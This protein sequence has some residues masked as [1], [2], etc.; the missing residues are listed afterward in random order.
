MA[1]FD[2]LEISSPASTGTYQ[3]SHSLGVVPKVAICFGGGNTALNGSAA[4]AQ[5]CLGF[6]TGGSVCNFVSGAAQD[7]VDFSNAYRRQ[8][9]STNVR[10]FCAHDPN[11]T[12]EVL[13]RYNAPDSSE[14]EL[15]FQ[16]TTSGYKFF[17]LLIGGDDVT[18]EIGTWV[19]GG[20]TVPYDVE[21]SGFSFQPE[22]LMSSCSGMVLAA[23]AATHCA[24][25]VGFETANDEGAV[26]GYWRDG[27]DTN[28]MD[29]TT[30]RNSRAHQ[31]H[32]FNALLEADHKSFD[33]DGY[34]W[35]AVDQTA[36][37]SAVHVLGI[38]GIDVVIADYPS[39]A[40]TGTDDCT[41][42]GITPEAVLCI[43]NMLTDQD[44]EVQ[45]DAY[46]AISIGAA[47]ST[48]KRAVTG[49]SVQ[50]NVDTSNCSQDHDN[51]NVLKFFTANGASPTEVLAADLDSF[52]AG[53]AVFDWSNVDASTYYTHVIGFATKAAA[54]GANPI[55][56]RRPGIH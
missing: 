22:F 25:A 26:A 23:A 56:F 49:A 47:V 46:T 3:F 42:A 44:A 51:T 34:T 50:R 8:K 41:L 30:R 18:A 2:L 20:G 27:Q 19:P 1:V 31:N 52:A 53:K 54:G 15:W 4:D 39:P 33:S 5:Y 38:S 40:S 24:F 7:N 9:T 17:V 48:T 16:N 12:L 6:A 32:S 11:G 45:A 37:N 14:I 21:F 35:T 29:R 43:N 13:A 55:F 10:F 36:D 28:S